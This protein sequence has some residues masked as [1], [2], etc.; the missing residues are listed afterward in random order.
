[1]VQSCW[2]VT[3]HTG[4]QALCALMNS[5]AFVLLA[6]G[7]MEGFVCFQLF[8]HRKLQKW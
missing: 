4:P 8:I 3:F 5:L 2:N 7:V 1:M 6:V